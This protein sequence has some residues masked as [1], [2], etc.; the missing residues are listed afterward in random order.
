[1]TIYELQ[2]FL[3]FI[4]SF[5]LGI[6]L[7]QECVN[8]LYF[9]VFVTITQSAGDALILL[10]KGYD[11]FIKADQSIDLDY[12]ALDTEVVNGVTYRTVKFDAYILTETNLWVEEDC[13]L[14]IQLSNK[15][16]SKVSADGEYILLADSIANGYEL[17]VK[18]CT[19]LTKRD[20]SLYVVNLT[21]KIVK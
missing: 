5:P 6:V 9:E 10:E 15:K 16:D 1:M 11:K 12:N 4:D 3:F 21:L 2:F 19:N 7:L 18:I 20:G 17:K 8:V 14:Q 13:G